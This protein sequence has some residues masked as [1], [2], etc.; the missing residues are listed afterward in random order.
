MRG[1]RLL[2]AGHHQRVQGRIGAKGRQNPRRCDP[3]ARQPPGQV[4]AGEP[5][6]RHEKR[7]DH[8]RHAAKFRD[9]PRQR[10][11]RG[12]RGACDAPA[13][14]GG[15]HAFGKGGKG[16]LGRFRVGWLPMRHD[17]GGTIG[18]RGVHHRPR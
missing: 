18:G 15:A 12:K 9:R 16:G 5:A 17:E 2:Q 8:R 7:I 6:I 1:Q 4:G 3:I 10:A 14:K 13:R 11:G